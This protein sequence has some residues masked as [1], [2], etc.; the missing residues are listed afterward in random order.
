MYFL[1]FR[2][3]LEPSFGPMEDATINRSLGALGGCDTRPQ[4]GISGTSF[5]E[6]DGYDKLVFRRTDAVTE[7]TVMETLC[8]YDSLDSGPIDH[9]VSVVDGKTLLRANGTGGCPSTTYYDFG[10]SIVTQVDA[11]TV[12]YDYDLTFTPDEPVVDDCND[13]INND[14][15]GLVD[16]PSDPGC[17][18]STDNELGVVEC[19]NSLDDDGDGHIDSPADDACLDPTGES[20][21]ACGPDNTLNRVYT[22]LEGVAALGLVGLPDPDFGTFG[23]G[24]RW[25]VGD[26]GPVI[27]QANATAS[28]AD[29]WVFLGALEE[30]GLEPFHTPGQASIAGDQAIGDAIFGLDVSP[31]LLLSSFLPTTKLVKALNKARERLKIDIGRLGRA[32]AYRE[33]EDVVKW[34]F[35]SYLSKFKTALAENLADIPLVSQRIADG[36][37]GKVAGTLETGTGLIV[38]LSDRAPAKDVIKK[39]L[40]KI[41]VE[42]LASGRRDTSPR[43]WLL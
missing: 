1:E 42:A 43:R 11:T 20:E 29:N 9:L 25:C 39:V 8:L 5:R 30:F 15:D 35:H 2:N 12:T 16:Y 21:A 7:P 31:A 22:T 14:F 23:L 26:D 4:F 17:T 19:D 10:S 32:E 37:A 38:K 41:E 28:L 27:E 33:F 24:V 6:P 36:F 3:E 18:S 34:E 13:G 40:G